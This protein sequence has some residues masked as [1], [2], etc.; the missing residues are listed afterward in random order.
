[1]A[2]IALGGRCGHRR[3]SSSKQA[4]SS[5]GNKSLPLGGCMPAGSTPTE[6]EP[7]PHPDPVGEGAG[8][9]EAEAEAEAEAGLGSV[10]GFS[11]LW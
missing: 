5:A 11:L 10:L 7:D 8:A 3:R 6:K 9:A 2:T 1:M 4:R